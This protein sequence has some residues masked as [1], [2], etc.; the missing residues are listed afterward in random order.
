VLWLSEGDAPTKIFQV[1]ASHCRRK[2]L[3]GSLEHDD[4]VLVAEDRKAEATYSFF[5]DI[6]GISAPH[7]NTINLEELELPHLD[8]SDLKERF[9]E[10]EVLGI[11]WSLPLD[12][13]LGPKCF[14][15]RFLQH[16]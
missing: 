15:A 4:R 10:E 6:L 11:I 13:A 3:I 7:C 16:T 12:K 5:H 2:N 9:T 14:T 1:Q 8:I